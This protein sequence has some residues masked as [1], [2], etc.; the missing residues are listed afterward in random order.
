[1]IEDMMLVILPAVGVLVTYFIMRHANQKQF[2]HL[3][4]QA[5]AKA[6]A[7]EYE[8]EHLL[9]EANVEIQ[10]KEVNL[11]KK[12]QDKELE[13]VKQK[14]ELELELKSLR[15]KEKEL[16][17]IKKNLEFREKRE[18]SFGFRE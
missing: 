18:G 15:K 6:A 8:A 11:E 17:K 12:F 14:T 10:Q 7:I 4:S 13:L 16:F 1:M 5:K 2:Q 3:E 9:H